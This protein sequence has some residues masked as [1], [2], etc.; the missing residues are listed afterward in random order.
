MKVARI[1]LDVNVERD[2]ICF[3][4]RR[5]TGI[6]VRLVLESLTCASGRSSAE[7]DEQRFVLFLSSIQCLVGIGDPV[8]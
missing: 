8:D 4:V 2:E 1:F 5:Q 7:I 6:A 3:D